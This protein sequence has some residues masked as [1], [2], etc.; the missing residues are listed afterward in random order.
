MAPPPIESLPLELRQMILASLDSYDSVR[1]AIASSPFF[2]RA[3]LRAEHSILS[4]ILR[5]EIDSEIF[6]DAII[7]LQ[8]SK[9]DLRDTEEILEMLAS[10]YSHRAV[11]IPRC[12]LADT[13]C[14]KLHAAVVFFA[15]AFVSSTLCKHPVTGDPE[16]SP[17]PPTATEWTRIQRAFYRFELYSVLFRRPVYNGSQYDIYGAVQK[18][19]MFFRRYSACEIE[20][21]ACVYE[22][23]FLHMSPGS[24]SL[25]PVFY[26]ICRLQSLIFKQL[27]L[28]LVHLHKLV[29]ARTYN[30]R[31]VILGPIP[32][33]HYTFHLDEKDVFDPTNLTLQDALHII[34]NPSTLDPDSGPVDA[35]RWAHAEMPPGKFACLG[36]NEGLRRNGYVMWDHARLDDWGFFDRTWVH[37]GHPFHGY[38]AS[39]IRFVSQY[40]TSRRLAIFA[41]GGRGWWIDRDESHLSWPPFPGLIAVGTTPH[42][43]R[44]GEYI[45]D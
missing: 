30:E 17:R 34:G 44:P 22:Y 37:N 24:S 26:R 38:H 33:C 45:I 25:P 20:Q 27:S 23:L 21:L 3:F 19:E 5:R 2:Y 35:W 11:P 6:P 10:W 16:T 40:S 14:S 7:A 8:V 41:S 39:E 32:H 18:R 1:T 36:A 15:D 31:L 4:E 43:I 13:T 42:V 12:T 28:G 9:I 29:T